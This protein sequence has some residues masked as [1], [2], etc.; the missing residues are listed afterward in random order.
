MHI[1]LS[2]ALLESERSEGSLTSQTQRG[3]SDLQNSHP[4]EVTLCCRFNAE[5]NASPLYLT[6]AAEKS[7][8]FQSLGKKVKKSLQEKPYA[9]ENHSNGQLPFITVTSLNETLYHTPCRLQRK[10]LLALHT[11][12]QCLKDADFALCL[13]RY[14]TGAV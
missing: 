5:D 12:I 8:F 13:G 4:S 9:M 7:H 6:E 10:L 11:A 3:Q 1:Q 2:E 14:K